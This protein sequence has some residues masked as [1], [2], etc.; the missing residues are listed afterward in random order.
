[1]YRH[2]NLA[3]D[4]NS[5]YHQKEQERKDQT[6]EKWKMSQSQSK[7]GDFLKIFSTVQKYIRPPLAPKTEYSQTTSPLNP[8]NYP[9][10]QNLSQ[11][12]LDP[13]TESS[14]SQISQPGYE[15]QPGNL[16]PSLPS[17]QTQGLSK[18]EIEYEDGTGPNISSTSGLPEIDQPKI[19]LTQPTGT[20]STKFFF[21]TN[22]I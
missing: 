10:S 19:G 7:I 4:R 3:Y 21:E 8:Q 9:T 6:F 22:S 20:S 18:P 12:H 1:M 15:G 11:S 16:G 5:S 13:S 14:S 2:V 17:S